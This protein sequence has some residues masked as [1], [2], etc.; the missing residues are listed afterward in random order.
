MRLLQTLLITTVCLSPTSLWAKD[1]LIILA[2]QSNMMG[3]GKTYELPATYK[4]TPANIQFF[5]QGRER[6]LAQFAYFGPEVSFAHEVARAFPHDNI[7]LVKQAA[8]GS[9]IK[10]WQAGQA[11][12]KGLLRQVGFAT[13]NKE[14][15]TVDAI[16]WMQGE[17][18]AQ[19]SL[20]VASQYGGQ[21]KQ[22]VDS[23]RQDLHSPHSLFIFGQTSLEHPSSKASLDT[24]RQQQ[25][26]M[27]RSL[28]NVSMV[29]TDK[30]GKLGD[31]I[32]LNATGQMELG[33]RF[34]KA[35]ISQTKQ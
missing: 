33:H 9:T 13:D 6:K 22:L 17:S 31:G 35:Y 29:T 4:Q 20:P 27:Q 28:E 3:R 23:L 5:Y 34:A 7:I 16:L 32:H 21:L 11:L 10:Q 2:G 12:Y 26:A 24:V 25:D 30:L 1:R 14:Q 18:D 19:S 15:Q 8:S